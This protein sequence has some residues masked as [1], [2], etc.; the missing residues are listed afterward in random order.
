MSPRDASPVIKR[1]LDSAGD[2]E[3]VEFERMAVFATY[4][5]LAVVASAWTVGA[6]LLGVPLAAAASGSFVVL[7]L[8]SLG[9]LRL[10]V[11]FNALL[12]V[13]LTAAILW[14]LG[15]HV[16]L[17]GFAASGGVVVWSSMGL[18]TAFA[19]RLSWA[20]RV[21]GLGFVALLLA[22]AAL[23]GAH[24]PPTGVVTP[25][26]PLF[27]LNVGLMCV[28][29]YGMLFR[30]RGLVIGTM[31][32]LVHQR[33]QIL[34]GQAALIRSERLA[35][36]GGLV[37]GVAHELNTPLG[38]IR[39]SATNLGESVAGTLQL[40]RAL[41]AMGDEDRERF[42]SLLEGRQVNPPPRSWKETRALK[43]RLART[44]EEASVPEPEAV[45]EDLLEL[46][47]EDPENHLPL[48][49]GPDR[50]LLL[51]GALNVV[52]LERNAANV[53]V[54]AG[55]AAKI[56]AALKSYARPGEGGEVSEG[57][58][59]ARLDTVLTLY[60]NQIRL[61]VDVQREYGDPGALTARHSQ[62]DQVWT[63]LVHNALQAMEGSG[64]L[65]VRVSRS[66]DVVA[67][68]VVDSGPGIPAD[69]LPNIFEPFFTTKGEG[70]GTGLGLSISR[71]IVESQGGTISVDSRVGRTA[72]RV[73]LRAVAQS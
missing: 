39:A 52:S 63:N 47:V 62:L 19:F 21:A 17:G 18:P 30:F 38:A 61:G 31:D 1:M 32:E 66:G 68:E 22:A 67:V 29:Q 26:G 16:A 45:A 65:T 7:G 6:L 24:A 70:E 64:T 53:E 54:A 48:L 58:L 35:A 3:S 55:R 2:D 40:P 20:P 59:T 11:P 71:E 5:M 49:T 28:L 73:E 9:L 57:L 41:N 46:G 33:G 14:P 23:D 72:F 13:V 50:D 36:L 43:R 25:E 51:R 60:S 42:A 4:G 44:L 69:V 56:V 12:A 8:V 15:V 34:S 37:A 27:L 10:G